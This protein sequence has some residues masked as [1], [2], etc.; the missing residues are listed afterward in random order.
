MAC[1][2]PRTVYQRPSGGA[3]LWARPP[4]GQAGIDY[5]KLTIPCGTCILCREEHARQTAVR[6]THEAQLYREN[7]FITLTYSDEHLPEHGSLNYE[8]LQKFWKRARKQLGR[9]RYYAVG[10]Y[11]DESLRPH[12]HAVVF[13]RAFIADRIIV[14]EQPTLLWTSP[15]LEAIWGLGQVTVGAVTFETARYCA[16]YVTKKLRSKQKYVRIDETTG[17]LIA[18][19][20]PRAFMSRNIAKGWW[21][22]YGQ[23]TA[24]HDFVVING[25]RQKPPKAYLRWLAKANP[26]RA[27]E[28]KTQRKE[29]AVNSP[30][31]KNRA[32]ARNAHARVKR[33][34]KSI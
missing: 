31:E 28:I 14:R 3:L 23:H 7:S 27:E 10:E 5:Y 34:S 21:E 8:H 22:R 12:Y 26:A 30:T 13:N 29:R 32:R 6:I 19:A 9:L 25:R 2:H 20:Q 16:S 33:K 18:L 24:D 11:G 17:E 1:E 4:G 15:L